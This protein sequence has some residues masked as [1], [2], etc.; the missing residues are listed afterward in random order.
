[1]E[2]KRLILIFACIF[3]TIFSIFYYFLFINTVSDK[4]V[5]KRILYM[6][7]VGLYKNQESINKMQQSLKAIGL[8]SYTLKADQLTAVICSLST[9]EKKTQQD[10]EKLTANTFTFIQKSIEI[11]DA[12]TISYYDSKEYQKALERIGK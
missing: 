3:S 11:K 4:N 2:N 9:D 5:G 6:N 8:E 1:M 10:Q 7:Q 12:K